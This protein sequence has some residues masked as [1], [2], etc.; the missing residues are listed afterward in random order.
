MP[1]TTLVYTSTHNIHTYFRTCPADRDRTSQTGLLRHLSTRVLTMFTQTSVRARRQRQNVTDRPTTTPVYTS[2]HNVHTDFRTCPETETE[3]HRQVYYDIC[4]HEYSQCSHR[5]SY[6]PGG[7][8][9][10]VTYRPTTTL[11]YTSTH[12]VHTYFHTCPADR[13]RTSQTGLL[14][15]MSTRVLTMF[16]QTSVRARRQRQNVTDRPTT[17]F[18]Y[19]STHNVHTDF[20]T[21][22]ADRDRTS[23]TGLLRHLSTRVL[24]MFTHTSI[25]ARRTETER[26]RQAYYDICL[27]E[28]SQCSHRL[29]YV[30]GDRD[31]TSQTGLLRHLSTRVLTMFTHTSIR[32]RRTETERHRQAYY[33]ICLHEYSQCSHR[34]AYVPGDRDRTSQTGLL[35]HLSTRVLTMF[36]QTSVRARRTET[37]EGVETSA[38]ILT[39]RHA[40]C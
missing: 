36:T 32:A 25:R 5:L 34:L 24:T 8:R 2:T 33:D 23:Q 13:D 4:L 38:A 17:T 22:P 35:R 28:Y 27:H 12:N 7:Q 16:T 6:V 40:Y 29:P 30:P 9:Q 15:H 39:P 20:R 19:T 1:T 11:V 18:V 26:H 10:N 21:C 31:R 3:R 14:R 37:E